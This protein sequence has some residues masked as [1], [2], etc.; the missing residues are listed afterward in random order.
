ME[1]T[2]RFRL[3]FVLCLLSGTADA[4][5][6]KE[7]LGTEP[8]TIERIVNEL[9]EYFSHPDPHGVPVLTIPEPI[10]EENRVAAGPLTL[11]DL[12]ISGHS[13]IR[14]DYVNVNLTSFT[15]VA[16]LSAPIGNVFGEY[17][18]PGWWSTSQGQANITMTNIQLTGNLILGVDDNGILT[19][20]SLK[21]SLYYLD[22][23]PHFTGLSTEHS[24]MVSAVD[25]FFNSIIEPL[26]VGSL[27]GK[28][29]K[30]LNTK[31]QAAFK[32][33]P[34]PDSISP[35]DYFIA[36]TRRTLRQKFDPLV[37]ERKEVS[38]AWEM[39]LVLKD[40]S[41]SGL[42]TIHR[43]HEVSAEFIDNAIFATVQMGAQKLKGGADWSLSAALMPAISGHIDIE[44]ETLDITVELKQPAN[45][46]SPP[47]L[48]KIDIQLGNLAVRSAG[49]RTMDYAVEILINIVPNIFRNVIMDKIEPKLHQ[50]IQRQLNGLDLH[51]IVM[52]KLAERR[53][54]QESSVTDPESPGTD[55]ESADVE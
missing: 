37:I 32:E 11:W 36:K 1:K 49:E 12:K 52:D 53:R 5:N 21:F 43:T 41:L 29:K 45:I 30:L 14:L 9:I 38:M 25:L 15:A 40:V 7:W 20:D 18:W 42:S 44:V 46:R 55:L 17:E 35:V 33:K 2:E 8:V 23:I 24:Y 31:L 19:A 50:V 16:R 10:Y 39:T 6:V 28:L 13:E 48:R 4:I 26:L 22:L 3:F 27:E 51:R 47:V 54:R 34:F